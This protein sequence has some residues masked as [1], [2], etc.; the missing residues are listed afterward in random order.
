M[1]NIIL[2]VLSWIHLIFHLILH[3]KEEKYSLLPFIFHSVH[4]HFNSV[5]SIHSSAQ[6]TFIHPLA[7]KKVCS[8]LNQD[9]NFVLQ[10]LKD[11]HKRFP[12]SS[13]ISLQYLFSFSLSH[14]IIYEK[15]YEKLKQ[16]ENFIQQYR[17]NKFFNCGNLTCIRS[18]YSKKREL[19]IKM[20]HFY[21]NGT[22]NSSSLFDLFSHFI[23]YHVPYM[24]FC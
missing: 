18:W 12:S 24:T 8:A 5:H 17:W 2:S 22:R 23:S 7:R 1:H 20:H 10:L 19:R 4:S 16:D 9:E 14:I 21:N 6:I 13:T 11:F 3:I 15:T